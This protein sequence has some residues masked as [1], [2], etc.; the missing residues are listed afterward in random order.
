MRLAG[1]VLVLV[2]CCYYWI[3]KVI[4]VANFDDNFSTQ[5]LM[6]FNLDFD[7][8]IVMMLIKY[9][10]LFLFSLVCVFVMK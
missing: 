6:Y 1:L 9:I 5:K 2:K 8:S 7:I 10:L 3:E 4:V